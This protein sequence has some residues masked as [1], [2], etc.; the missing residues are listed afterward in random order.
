MLLPTLIERPAASCS[1]VWSGLRYSSSATWVGRSLRVSEAALEA[2]V[3]RRTCRTDSIGGAKSTGAGSMTKGADA[4]A[5]RPSAPSSNPIGWTCGT[6]RP[7]AAHQRGIANF[8]ARTRNRTR[9]TR[10][11]IP[12][13]ERRK[14]GVRQEIAEGAA[15]GVTHLCQRSAGC[16]GAQLRVATGE[17]MLNACSASPA[18]S[19]ARKACS[20]PS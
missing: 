11:F 16:A 3:A 9:D 5:A 20:S 8:G 7:A 18:G 6:A 10:I 12:R 15:W 13:A 19:S 4:F 17:G 14:R 2:Y 1:F